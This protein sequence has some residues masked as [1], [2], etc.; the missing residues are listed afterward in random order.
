G[1]DDALYAGLRVIEI[2]AKTGQTIPELLK[3][4]PPA[5]CT[6]EIRV[7][8]TE[9]KKHAIVAKL[10]EKFALASVD[11]KA[12][13]L[14]GIRVSFKDGW[15]LA[16]ASNTQPVLVLRFESTS[17]EGLDRIQDL[18]VSVVEPMLGHPIGA[19]SH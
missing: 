13:L 6:P 5:F 14:D 16:R 18:F 10:K 1:Y 17:Q 15:A 8:T 2:L 7:D 12:D 19:G 9:E 4:F 3:E 11:Y